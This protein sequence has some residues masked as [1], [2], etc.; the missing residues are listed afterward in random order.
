MT[1]RNRQPRVSALSGRHPAVPLE[2]EVIP[3]K[4]ELPR[5]P[6]MPE[7][8]A[9]QKLTVSI[10]R[11]LAEQAR[12]A[13]WSARSN[14]RTFSGWVE[15]AISR[16]IEATKADQGVADLPRRPGPLPAGRPVG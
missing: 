11:E 3:A 5:M 16:H 2:M 7:I 12:D 4:T 9:T 15:E 13:Y 10:S 1:G 6:A 14:Y 8:P